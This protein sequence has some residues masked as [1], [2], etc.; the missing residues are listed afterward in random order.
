MSRIDQRPETIQDNLGQ[1]KP[2]PL[3]AKLD[4]KKSSRKK[5]PLKKGNLSRRERKHSFHPHK[6]QKRHLLEK[7]QKSEKTKGVRKT[8]NETNRSIKLEKDPTRENYGRMTVPFKLSSKY[9]FKKWER[10]S[11]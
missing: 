3:E 10:G 1:P 11:G 8:L 7:K 4:T 6:K 5:P 9:Y 2:S